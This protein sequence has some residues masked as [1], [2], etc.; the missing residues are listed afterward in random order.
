MQVEGEDYF[1]S[2][3]PVVQWSTGRWM[4]I[5][6]IVYGMHTRQV[7]YV[8][9]FA[10]ANIKEEVYIEVP[11]GYEA[12]D[13]QDCVLKLNK[14]LYGMVQAPLAFFDLLKSTLV[15]KHGFRQMVNMDPCLFVRDDMIC[16]CYVDDCLWFS[17]EPEKMDAVIDAIDKN[18]LTLT[19]ESRD[20]SAFL[21]IQFSRSGKMIELTQFGLIDRIIAATGMEKANPCRTPAKPQPLGSSKDGDPFNESWSYASVIG[22]LLYLASNS[23]PDIANYSIPFAN[24]RSWF[25]NASYR[26]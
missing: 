2:Y 20:V 11:R 19:V 10:Q 21:G 6:S 12:V 5:L 18:D 7:D 16:L 9:A 23:R 24:S 26:G 15:N 17:L 22:M 25:A 8:N 1:E 4:L 13:E 3:A 14:S